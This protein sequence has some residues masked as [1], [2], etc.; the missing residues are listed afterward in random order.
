MGI[1]L[2]AFLLTFIGV[3]SWSFATPTAASPDEPDQVI[4]AVAVAHGEFVGSSATPST[5]AHVYVTV[6]AS[7]V[8]LVHLPGCY[9]GQDDVTPACSPPLSLATEPLQVSIYIGRYPPLYYALVGIPSW[10]SDSSGAI[11]AMRL[12]SAALNSLFLALA[13]TAVMLWS[14]RRIG[15]IGILLAATP[16]VL[17]LS[18]VVNSNGLEISA[19]IALWTALL[20]LAID[21]DSEIVPRALVAIATVAA[22]TE[23]LCRA[24]SPLWVAITILLCAGVAGRQR[25]RVLLR[26]R[27]VQIGAGVTV[28]MAL[29][30]AAWTVHFH[31]TDVQVVT[32]AAA[33]AIT[34]PYSR[35][36]LDKQALYLKETIG[37]FGTLD[38]PSPGISYLFWEIGSGAVI[39]LALLWAKWSTR[40]WTLVAATCA[41]AV[42]FAIVLSEAAHLHG[43]IWQGRDGAPLTLGIPLLGAALLSARSRSG[44]FEIGVALVVLGLVIVEQVGAFAGA[45]NRYVVGFDRPFDFYSGASWQPPLGAIT[46][47]I[48]TCLAGGV[49]VALVAFVIVRSVR[50]RPIAIGQ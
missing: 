1:F 20:L 29:L 38:V 21:R 15:L 3:A 11:Y 7:F 41:V 37:D 39:L 17:F 48:A 35:A 16:Q 30:A 5:T 31:A 27:S 47:L 24:L 13:I 25:L 50:A 9:V 43:L 23:A 45:L 32:G 2:L 49:S 42:P 6:P 8:S 26:A 22:A 34:V 40:I 18:G 44:R 46:L 28:V 14:K 4:K 19:A 33:Q 36:L 12:V 10:F